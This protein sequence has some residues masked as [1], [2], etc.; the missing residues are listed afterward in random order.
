M[1]QILHMFT[2]VAMV[3]RL[4]ILG[5]FALWIGNVTSPTTTATSQPQMTCWPLSPPGTTSYSIR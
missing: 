2:L 1:G 3:E 4:L 5:I